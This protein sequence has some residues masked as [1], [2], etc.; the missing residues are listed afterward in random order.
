MLIRTT[1]WVFAI[2]VLLPGCTVYATCDAEEQDC[3]CE[4]DVDCKLSVY[5]EEVLAQEE[6]YPTNTC[7]EPG[8]PINLDADIRN[9]MSWEDKGCAARV[10]PVDCGDEE[11]D[12]HDEY[13][14]ECRQGSCA[15]IHRRI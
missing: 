7:C 1:L 13:S 5:P 15:A 6:C 11:C 10:S 14:A 4:K 8:A 12:S 3:A 2:A 9:R